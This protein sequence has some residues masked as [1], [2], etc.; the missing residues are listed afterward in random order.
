VSYVMCECVWDRMGRDGMG[1]NEMGWAEGEHGGADG[2]L[3]APG[4]YM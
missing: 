4:G 3:W 1:R 2:R